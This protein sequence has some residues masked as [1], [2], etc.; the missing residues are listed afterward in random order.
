MCRL[1]GSCLYSYSRLAYFKQKYEGGANLTYQDAQLRLLAYVRSQI[2]NGELT[3]RGFARLIGISQPHVHN[4]LKGARN[5]SPNIFD[6]ALKYFHLTLLDL[7]TSS[8]L[9]A[10]LLSLRSP[11]RSAEVPFLA[12][13]IG[14][15]MPWPG[16]N[17]R[18][19]F[20]LP[21]PSTHAPPN[22]VI[23][24]LIADPSMRSTLGSSD[25]ALL[26]L[27]PSH[28]STLAPQGLFVVERGTA[29]GMEAVI[30][31]IRPGTHRYYLASDATLDIPVDWEHFPVSTAE[32]AI[33]VK[34]R[35]RWIGSDWIGRER[36]RH[37]LPQRGRFLYDPIS[38]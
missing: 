17:L 14:P 27:S 2:Q 38:S 1:P 18:K 23:A 15:G 16:L 12:R 24:S 34:A 11:Q 7:V 28:P 21:F 8:E 32:L 29:A 22:L 13:P 19:S 33:A 6:L 25:I 20:P 30:R 3:E 10:H 37:A 35:V 36:E 31:Y 5:L 9:E 26:D 4:V